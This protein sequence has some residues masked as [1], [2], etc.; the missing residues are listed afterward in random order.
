MRLTY[1]LLYLVTLIACDPGIDPTIIDIDKLYSVNS[2]ISPQDSTHRVYLYR[3]SLLGEIANISKAVTRNA[4]VILS[5]GQTEDTL[6]LNATAEYYETNTHNV[7]VR[8]FNTYFLMVKIE[9][10][11]LITSKCTVPPEPLKPEFSG[12]RSDN[13]YDF[14]ISWKN[15]QRHRYFVVSA[16]AEGNYL[17]D[18]PV[19]QLN[20]KLRAELQ[21]RA[22]PSNN[23]G[24]ANVK[25]GTV[26]N[27]FLSN[28][29]KLT[30]TIWYVDENMFNYYSTWGEYDTWIVNASEA[31]PNFRDPK[32][33]YSNIMGGIGVFAASNSASTTMT[34]K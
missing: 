11:G 23:Q 6:S 32:P 21:E 20:L 9:G 29:P 28:E 17:A 4:L 31:V 15:P 33:I 24:E 12:T 8:E 14:E 5:D 19:G 34:I 22:F 16:S 25:T 18:T 2:F 10:T 27:A 1:L 3:A 30:G 26:A 13:N 7:T